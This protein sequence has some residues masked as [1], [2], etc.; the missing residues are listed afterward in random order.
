MFNHMKMSP[1]DSAL[2]LWRRANNASQTELGQRLGVHKSTICRWERSRVPA[3]RTREIA[4]TLGVMP[5]ELRPDL[6]GEPKK[7][8]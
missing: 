2:R 5:F 7:R 4:N 3:E 6:Y 1:P 8:A